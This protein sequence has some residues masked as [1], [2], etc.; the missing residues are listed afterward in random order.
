[1]ST[2]AFRDTEGL[3]FSCVEEA[4][5]I[6]DKKGQTMGTRLRLAV[7]GILLSLWSLHAALAQQDDGS[8][9][10]GT[11]FPPD[12][13]VIKNYYLGVPVIG[14]GSNRGPHT[15]VPVIFLHGNNDTP[16]PTTCNQ[17]FG[18]I[19]DFAQFF[20]DSGYAAGELWGL[21]YQGD[22][23]D[24]LQDPT[25]RS[26]VAHST[27]AAVPLLR[28]FVRAVL[29]YTGAR[30][31]DI[32]AHSLGV[33]VAREFML[34][35]DAYQQVRAL[36]AI[37]GPNHG[38]INCSPSPLNFWQLPSNGGFTPNSA[39]CDEY[40]SD[41]TQLLATLNAAGETA[42]PT[43]YLVIRNVS[44]ASPESGDFVYL[45]S[46]DGVFPGV[47]AQ[48]RYGNAHDFSGSALLAGAPSIDVV[49]QGQYDPIL[50]SAHLGILNSPDVWRAALQFLSP[51]H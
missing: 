48:D 35:D 43:R 40:G 21:G 14:F 31:V 51:R 23:C 6:R 41:R 12:F 49:G 8:G 45:P 27:A 25:L 22:Q 9:Q 2:H 1:L 3:L 34:Q 7:A 29:K 18:H 36:V 11:A 42:G 38:I 32:V 46:Q 47:P 13:P 39:V 37:D 20:R 30:Q 44:R 16:F 10:L 26:G 4:P 33:T 28:A 15:H 19:H 5:P 24:L 17:F 50:Q